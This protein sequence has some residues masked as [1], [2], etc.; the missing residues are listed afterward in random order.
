MEIEEHIKGI[1]KRPRRGLLIL[2]LCVVCFLAGNFFNGYFGELGR[3][4]AEKKEHPRSLKQ[5]VTNLLQQISPRILIAARRGDA[6]MPIW[7]NQIHLAQLRNL[8][9]EPTFS[10][11]LSVQALDYTG[12]TVQGNS[13]DGEPMDTANKGQLTKCVLTFG[14]ELRK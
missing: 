11:Y 10:D 7:I 13:P 8:S 4:C 3:R 1:K 5:E 2:G 12:N 6:E 9:R 14:D